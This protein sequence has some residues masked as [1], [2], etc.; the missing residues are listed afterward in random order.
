MCLLFCFS[1]EAVVQRFE[2]REH[3][4]DSRGVAEY[5]RALVITNAITEYLPDEHSGKPSTLPT[6]V[7]YISSL[8]PLSY[9]FCSISQYIFKLS[10][11]L[12]MYS[13]KS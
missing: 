8:L 13:C 6:L 10:L 4:V 1:P 9:S 7:Y 2:Q 12:M 3:A 11:F 5:I